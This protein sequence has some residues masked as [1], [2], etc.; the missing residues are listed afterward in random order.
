MDNLLNDVK[1]QDLQ[2]FEFQKQ[3]AGKWETLLIIT[4]LVLYISL[5]CWG[6]VRAGFRPFS[7][8]DCTIFP[9]AMPDVEVNGSSLR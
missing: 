8:N 9:V 3:K 2:D 6:M 4:G 5:S 7:A 1:S